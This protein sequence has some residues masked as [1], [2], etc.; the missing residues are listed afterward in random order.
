[1]KRYLPA[2]YLGFSLGIVIPGSLFGSWFLVKAV[3]V[4]VPFWLL[5][6]YCDGS[7]G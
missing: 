6:Y 4:I 2:A 7:K 5:S 1:M 3:F